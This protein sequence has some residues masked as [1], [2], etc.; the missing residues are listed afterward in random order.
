[1]AAITL[2]NGNREVYFQENTGALRRAVY[3]SQANLWHTST[4][5]SFPVNARNN[6]PLAAVNLGTDGNS[7]ALIYVLSENNTL[8]CAIWDFSGEPCQ[9]NLPDFVVAPES[10]QVSI[11]SLF[12]GDS[13]QILLLIFEEPSGNLAFMLGSL[14]GSVGSLVGSVVWT[15]RN[16]TDQLT[17]AQMSLMNACSGASVDKPTSS[18]TMYCFLKTVKTS[19]TLS[20]DD[21]LSGIGFYFNSTSPDNH[22][23]FYGSSYQ[24]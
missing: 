14:V 15:W 10:R 6:T 22:S 1:M 19:S 8:Y 3:S 7:T 20:P 21:E 16:E 23:S 12:S 24:L 11:S 4:D 2:P 18:V 5:E 13:L 9:P 17:S